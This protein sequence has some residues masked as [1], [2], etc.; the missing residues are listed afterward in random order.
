M[1][2][3]A[4]RARSS[5]TSWIAFAQ[6]V[7]SAH[8]APKRQYLRLLRPESLP[9]LQLKEEGQ[10]PRPKMMSVTRK[11]TERLRSRMR[12][13]RWHRLRRSSASS[14]ISLRRSSRMR[15]TG[16]C[17]LRRSS[18]S[19]ETSVTTV[20]DEVVLDAL[21]R[22]VKEVS[23]SWRRIFGP[24]AKDEV[25]RMAPPE[26]KQ[27]VQVTPGLCMHKSKVPQ[28]NHSATDID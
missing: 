3:S 22:M 26:K 2:I 5:E 28:A 11:L 21:R 18:A 19:A 16:W 1:T 14:R 15:S 8:R 24:L 23:R 25:R 7:T 6:S 27:R 10:Q 20:Q 17:R 9:S 4:G 12:S 13:T